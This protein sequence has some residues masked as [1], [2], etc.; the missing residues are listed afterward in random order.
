MRCPKRV[1]RVVLTARGSFPVYP[2]EQTF[3]Q[4]IGMSQRCQK[5]MFLLALRVM[6]SDMIYF[7]R[8]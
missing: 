2:D 6:R 4:S 5:E 3:S 7:V 8:R 1:S